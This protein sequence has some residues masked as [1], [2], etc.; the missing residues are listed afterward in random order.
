MRKKAK[1][2]KK[3]RRVF[4]VMPDGQDWIVRERAPRSD[5]Y[6]DIV[7]RS[8]RFDRKQEAVAYGMKVARKAIPSSLVIHKKDGEIQEERTY[9]NDPHPPKG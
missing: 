8:G 1:P 7:R 3:A 9:G 4:D 2:E 5:T 6:A